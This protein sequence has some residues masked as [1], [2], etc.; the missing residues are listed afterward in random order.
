LRSRI[1]LPS[2]F[3]L[4]RVRRCRKTCWL[5][6]VRA[7]RTP[8]EWQ[9]IKLAGIGER[10]FHNP[11]ATGR[12]RWSPQWVQQRLTCRASPVRLN[13]QTSAETARGSHECR[14]CCRSRA[15]SASYP[16]FRRIQVKRKGACPVSL[17]RPDGSR[18]PAGT[19]LPFPLWARERGQRCAKSHTS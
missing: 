8:G 11:L 9:D 2:N 16:S 19:A 14:Y 3:F 6:C 7:A 4:A 15:L 18:A 10:L 17:G 1:Y 13:E 12:G 5:K